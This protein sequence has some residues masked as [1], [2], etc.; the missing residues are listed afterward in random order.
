MASTASERTA[1]RGWRTPLGLRGSG[2]WARNSNKF[3]G[4]D[5]ASP[6]CLAGDLPR[7]PS[8]SL[9]S[10]IKVRTAL[11]HVQRPRAPD[12][13]ADGRAQDVEGPGYSVAVA[14]R[15]SLQE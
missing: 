7:L 3:D 12:R 4:A 15:F 2:T 11:V 13:F 1:A 10:K 14:S 8:V 5:T 6:S 9:S